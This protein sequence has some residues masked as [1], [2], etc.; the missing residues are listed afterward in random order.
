MKCPNCGNAESFV[1][2]TRSRADFVSRR[3]NCARCG[4]RFLTHETVIRPCSDWVY[5]DK[6]RVLTLHQLKSWQE[7]LWIETKSYG[8]NLMSATSIRSIVDN[9]VRFEN[10]DVRTVG[11]YGKQWRAWTKRPTQDDLKKEVW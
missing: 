7:A 2:D 10:G 6:T 8:G 3:R 9:C 4:C 1:T 11:L 5:G